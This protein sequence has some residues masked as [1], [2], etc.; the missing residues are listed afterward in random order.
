[1]KI[2][3]KRCLIGLESCLRVF[4]IV[5]IL[6]RDF[7]RDLERDLGALMGGLTRGDPTFE[8]PLR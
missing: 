8:Y 4:F 5:Y 1:M 2:D 7:E 3:P 6:K